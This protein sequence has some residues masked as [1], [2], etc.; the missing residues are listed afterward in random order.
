MLRQR[1]RPRIPTFSPARGEKERAEH[2]ATLQIPFAGNVPR[3]WRA[4][5]PPVANQTSS[6][7]RIYS[8]SQRRRRKP[9]C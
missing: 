3:Q 4:M 9:P 8:S 2:A 5:S 1:Q 7:L 6:R